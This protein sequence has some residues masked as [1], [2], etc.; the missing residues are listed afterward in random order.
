MLPNGPEAFYAAAG[1]AAADKE[2]NRKLDNASARHLEHLAA[3]KREFAA[4]ESERDLARRIKEESIERLDRLL[5]ELRQRLEARGVKVFFA[6]DAAGARDYILKVAREGGVKRVVKGKSMTTEEIGLNPALEQAGIEAVETDLGEYIVQLRREPPSHIIT[7]AIHLSSEDIGHLFAEKLG[8]DYSSDPPALTAVARARLRDKFLNAEMGITGV[9]FAVAETGTLVVVENEGNGRFC[10]TAPDIHVAVMGIEKVIP[11]FEDLSHFLEILARTATGQ[12]FTAYTSFLGAPRGANELDGPREMHL[13][14]LDNGRTRMLADPVMREALYCLRCGACLNVCPVYRHIG[15]HAYKSA[16]PGPIGSIVSPGLFGAAAAGHLPFA[17]TLCGAC[18]E[19]C[20]V[21]IDIPRILLHLRWKMTEGGEKVAWPQ[22]AARVRTAA[23][24]FARAARYPGMVRAAGRLGAVL[25]K[26]FAH[27]GYLRRMPGPFGA[28]TRVRDFPA[29]PANGAGLADSD[30]GFVTVDRYETV[31][32]RI[33]RG[34]APGAAQ[35]SANHVEPSPPPRTLDA[36]ELRAQF[37]A[38][39][40]AVGASVIEAST[41]AAA[42]EKIAAILSNAGADSAAIGAGITIDSA[43]VTARLSRGGCR[44]TT[45]GGPGA[46]QAALKESLA[47]VDAGIVEAD[48]GIASSGTLVMVADAAR[49]RSLSLLPPINIVMLRAARILPDLA[50][51][52]RIVGPQ[53]ASA[54]PIV[55]ITGPSRTADIEK[56]I[57]IGVHGPSQLHIVIVW[58]S[59]G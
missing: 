58:Q 24:W 2:L 39:A 7:P 32:A 26:P 8:M 46:T 1:K 33:R 6:A 29:P 16:Y 36:D 31:M 17:S 50:A 30:S 11:K 10:I 43:A 37:I 41:A 21:K 15:G 56:R 49:P 27:D 42:V 45:V 38:A 28:W 54:H 35:E 14:I 23:R 34:L 19:I 59:G 12:R 9:N 55:M 25:L 4:Y 57:V 22:A 20:P 5:S 13:V 48:Y 51:V 47:S 53:A 18:R 40:G 44:I 3:A 52:L